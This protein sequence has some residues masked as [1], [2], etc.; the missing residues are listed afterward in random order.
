[1]FPPYNPDEP[2]EDEDPLAYWGELDADE[3][4]EGLR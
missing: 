2:W 3:S 1:M 4:E